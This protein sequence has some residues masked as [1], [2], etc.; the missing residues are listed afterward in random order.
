MATRTDPFRPLTHPGY[1]PELLHRLKGLQPQAQALHKLLTRPKTPAS[2]AAKAP[3]LTYLLEVLPLLPDLGDYDLYPPQPLALPELILHA[4]GKAYL[5]PE[6]IRTLGLRAGQ[7]ATLHPPGWNSQYWHLDL[8]PTAPHNIDWYPG[9]RAKI[10]RIELPPQLLLPE[11][12][13]TL[14]LLPGPPAYAGFY[15]MVPSPP[16]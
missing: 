2:L 1:L 7:P 13:L 10:K 6:L 8:R 4:T 12:G 14:L 3:L 11:N 9:K 16:S 15:P 5:S